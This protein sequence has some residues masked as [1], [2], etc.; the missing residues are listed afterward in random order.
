MTTNIVY[1]KTKL[2]LHVNTEFN[3][4]YLIDLKSKEN[5]HLYY[6]TKNRFEY[7]LVNRDDFYQNIVD[8]I[9]DKISGYDYIIVP[10]SS[11]SFISTIAK[12]MNKTVYTI[13]KSSKEFI[14]QNISELK[15]QKAE[16]KSHLERIG[17]ME[18]SF[19]I[20]AMKSNQRRK[21]L[22]LLFKKPDIDF[23]VGKGIIIDDSYFSGITIDSIKKITNTSDV[24]VIFAK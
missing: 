5:M 8:A 15:L 14:V 21:Y 2:S 24:L 11:Q 13:H 3:F 19:K 17:E 1:S 20:N 4:S 9:Q 23:S 22:N 18:G 12:K 6:A 10:E 16:L 7:Q